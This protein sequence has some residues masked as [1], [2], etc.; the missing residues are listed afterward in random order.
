[1]RGMLWAYLFFIV[2]AVIQAFV[3]SGIALLAS[4]LA[5]ELTTMSSVRTIIKRPAK[6][7]G[8]L[9]RQM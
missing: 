8:L 1:M 2:V 3:A 7:A 6:A 9:E 5:E 4:R